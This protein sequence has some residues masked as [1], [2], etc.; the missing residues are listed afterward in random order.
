M[1]K[2]W[3]LPSLVLLLLSAPGA[4]GGEKGNVS[5]LYAGSLGAL[6]EK[7][8]GPAF[9]RASGYHYQGEGQGSVGGA[10]AIHDRLRAPDVFISADPAVNDRILMGPANGGF[11]SWYLTFASGELVLGY[12][13]RSR[14]RDLFEQ[15]Q[16]G[17]LPWY[18]VLARPGVKLGRTDPDL[19]PKGYR[20]LFLFELAEDYY[21][22]PGLAALLGPPGSSDQIFP[23]PELLIRMESGQLDVAVFYRHEVVAHGIPYIAL[24]G[25]INQG[26]PRFAALYAAHSFTTTK[27]LKLTGSPTLF[28]VSVLN[29]AKNPAGAIA[30]VRFL[31]SAE[32]RALLEKAGLRAASL[33]LTGDASA[34]PPELKP[35]IQETR[36]P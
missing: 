14:F 30:F 8:V 12:N 27:G 15:A 34:L 24:P 3:L 35:L 17:K 9:E 7:S 10:R 32:G 19:D 25:E 23:E 29:P 26:D 33:S 2:L 16:A 4:T 21:K 20:T 18:E 13:P 6:M 22:K 11:E 31:G 28:T 5:V 1:R 36:S